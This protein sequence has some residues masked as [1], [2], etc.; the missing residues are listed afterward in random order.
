MNQKYS[1]CQSNVYFNYALFNVKSLRTWHLFV[2]MKFTQITPNLKNLKN[3]YKYGFKITFNLDLI[4]WW[5][6]HGF[7]PYHRFFLFNFVWGFYFLKFL[8]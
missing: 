4:V 5:H 6:L 2:I 8:M 7:L 3:A 1:W